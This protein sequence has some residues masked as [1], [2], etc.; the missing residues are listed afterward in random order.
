[1]FQVIRQSLDLDT[2][3]ATATAA[4]AELLTGI[5]CLVVQYLP[6]QRVWR[7]IAEFRHDRT[8]PSTLGFEIPDPGNPFAAQ[9]KQLQMVRVENHDNLDAINRE[10]VRTL[11]GAWLLVPLVVDHRIWGSLTL[12]TTTLPYTWQ[13][14]QVELAQGISHQ[15][16]IAIQ[17]AQLY[18]QVEQ[19]KQKLIASQ[20]ALTQAQQLTQMGNWE[21]DAATQTMQWSDNLYRIFGFDPA[22]PQPDFGTIMADNVHPEDRPRLEACLNLALTEGIP[23]DIDLRFF[24][25][26]GSMGYMEVKA[27]PIRDAQGRIV[28]VFGTSMDI[29]DRKQAEQ[30]LRDSERR[31]RN[32]AA[33]VPGAIFKYVLHPD[34]TDAVVYMSPGCFDLW[35]VDAA[36]VIQD[37]SI[38]WRQVHPDDQTAM[39]ESVLHSARTLQPWYWQWRIITPSGQL[40]WLEAAGRP[41]RC[42]NGDILWDTLTLDVSDRKRAES[43]LHESEV[44]YRKV[45][46]A[47]TDFIL[48][49]LPDTTITFANP[50]LCRALG[51]ASEAIV[52]QKWSAFANAEDLENSAFRAIAEL[53]LERPR[54]FVEN[55]D[56]RAD[57]Q[58]GWT[59]WLNE[60][61]FDESGQ[62]I[63][64]QSVG[65]DIT[66]LKQAEQALR[67]SEERLR[68]V[69]AN[70]TDLVCLHDLEGHFTYAT[71]S[72][73]SLLGYL[74]EAL[75]G[76]HPYDL[77]HPDDRDQVRQKLN[78]LTH[79]GELAVFTYRIQQQS[80]NYIWLET[81]V[82]PIHQADGQISHLQ[83]TSRDV[84]DRIRAEQQLKHDA[85]H[86]RLTGLPNRSLLI[87][88]LDLALKR[89]RRHPDLQF[90]VLFLDLDN[91]KV[92]N[93]SLG[94]IVGDE[95]LQAITHTLQLFIRDTDLAAR[96]GGDEFV[97][98]LEEIADLSEAVTVAERILDMLRSPIHIAGQDVFTSAS[99]GIATGATNY[100][101]AAELIR[102]SDLAMYRAKQSGRGQYAIFDP[103]MHRQ[104]ME[105]LELENDLRRALDTQEFVLH[106]QPIIC[107]K[108]RIIR[109]F[110]ALIR[111][112]HPR[113]GLIMP[114]QF[115]QLAEE[116][117]L[118]VA[119]GQWVLR[120]ACRQLA[121]WQTQFPHLSLR[122]SVNLSVKQL[123]GLILEHLDEALAVSGLD[124]NCLV[125]EITES[126]LV[127]N[128]DITCQLL[129]Q[130]KDRGVRLSID[131]FGT[132][133]SSLSYLHRLPVDYLKIDRAFVSLN[134]T[135]SRNQLIAESIIALSNLLELGAVAE[136]I[137]TPQQLNWLEA[138]GCEFGQGNLFATALSV[139]AA[140]QWLHHMAPNN[141][142][143]QCTDSLSGDC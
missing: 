139:E 14:D 88:R 116:T 135:D 31:F 127:Q 41:E 113:R 15:L 18:Q 6:E 32:M 66:P 25:A 16:E 95:L 105:R 71:P 46:E 115:I 117:G 48:R 73:L 68:L 89:F 107:L 52:G 100:T 70:M 8:A 56:T 74:P 85:L 141:M 81:I 97:I 45:V 24:R 72:S 47:Q 103:T 28:K 2:I 26:D 12:N 67:N 99:I 138:L 79:T 77:I 101:T 126:M 87:E 4:I 75:L 7:H 111:W 134:E 34:G 40:K 36:E 39:Y 13:A 27:E 121:T 5:D 114:G 140:T 102:D 112:Q 124:S 57:G 80:G 82:K 93:D 65:R 119:I 44:R 122:M 61:I 133:Y 35:E 23:Y 76:Q 130:I 59:Q 62:L 58:E 131:D 22:E 129:D 43:A 19:E 110:E 21:L 90:A 49:S 53:S 92:V 128:V 132:G 125:L 10:V 63:E 60:G 94:H 55:R 42:E 108:K 1:M 143:Q 38:L 98:L 64:I 109:G 120:T 33:N 30:A 83:S 91:F 50:A 86:D 17:Q 51:V 96:L 142:Q 3:F 136:G 78:H 29:S 54:C 118:I 20:A 104:M 11:P 84:S 9:L 106:Y 37:A 123:Q 137:E 69:T